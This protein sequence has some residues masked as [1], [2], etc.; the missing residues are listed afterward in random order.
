MFPASWISIGTVCRPDA[1]QRAQGDH[2]CVLCG[3]ATTGERLV[4]LATT[5]HLVPVAETLD[6]RED[7]GWFPVGPECA[8]KL[9]AAHIYTEAK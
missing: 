1:E 2:P 5:G 6:E 9:T 3:K 7:Q 4:H 8:R